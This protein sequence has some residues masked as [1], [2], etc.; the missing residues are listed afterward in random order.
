MEFVCCILIGYFIGCINPA[1]FIGKIKGIDVKRKGSKNAGASNALLLF[2]KAFGVFCAVFDIFKAWLAIFIAKEILFVTYQYAFVLTAVSS[3]FGHIFP[4][5]MRFRGG[6]GL[7]SFGGMVLSYDWRVFLLMLGC[8]VVVALVSNYL[9]F[10][11]IGASIAFPI[12]YGVQR[13]DALGA[14]LLLL[15]SAVM[16]Y[17]HLENVKRVFKGEEIRVSYLWNKKDELK[18]LKVDDEDELVGI[19]EK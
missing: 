12:I 3:I 13:G 10:V 6:K 17:K 14:I 5:Y 4:F 9:C 2:G 18:R 15:P 19:T 1:Y 11:T 7:A 16:I 8:A